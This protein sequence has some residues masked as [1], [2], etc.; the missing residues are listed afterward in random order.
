VKG[1]FAFGY[2]THKDRITKPMIRASIKDAWKEVSWE[3]AINYAASELNAFR[4]NTAKIP[5]AA[6]PLHVA[7][8]KKPI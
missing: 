3:E 2:A 6:S 5:S 8:T 4:P 1:R 7:P